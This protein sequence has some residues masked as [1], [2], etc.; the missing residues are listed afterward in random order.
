M[1]RETF[2]GMGLLVAALT[3]PSCGGSTPSA[4]ATPAPTPVPTPTPAPTPTPKPLTV[5]KACRLPPSS[6]PKSWEPNGCD[7]LKGRDA[8]RLAP[9]V[10]AALD[11]VLVER[12]DLFNFGDMNGGN[13]RVLDRQA[14]HVAVMSALSDLDVCGNIEKEEIAIKNTNDF[15]EQWN[16]WT[17]SSFVWRKYETTCAPAWF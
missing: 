15:N 7:K 3:L 6:N 1:K 4:P 14:Y 11:R 5:V 12:P 8:A 13:P 17:S 9:Q 16:I 2:L 10:N